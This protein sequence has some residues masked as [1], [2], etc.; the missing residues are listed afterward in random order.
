MNIDNGKIFN[1]D[2]IEKSELE[3]MKELLTPINEGDMTK[4]QKEKMEV[5]LKDH[6]SKLGKQLTE[7]RKKAGLSKGSNR[8][9][10]RN[11]RKKL[12]KLKG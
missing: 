10:K 1:V 4:K 9:R 2:K 5:S 3:K 7:A 11:L 12:R 6:K 8:N